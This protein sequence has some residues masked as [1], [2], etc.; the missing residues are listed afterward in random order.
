MLGPLLAGQALSDAPIFGDESADIESMIEYLSRNKTS[1]KVSVEAVNAVKP[2]L[3]ESFHKANTV[4]EKL[5]VLRA[6]VREQ[7]LVS[8]E[9]N[10]Q[11]QLGNL[12]ILDPEADD[13]HSA[14]SGVGS[15]REIHETLLST[16]VKSPGIPRE[17]QVV[18]DH[19][20]LLRAKEK[21][22]FD[23]E[24]NRGIARDD[25]WTRFIWDWVAG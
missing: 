9:S 1:S 20:M 10:L 16:L 11:S 6:F 2:R 19:T 18:V 8:E 23:A 17:A 5:R 15:C 13:I 25:P 22:L 7:G 3:P 24:L 21:Y 12:K 14:S 4:A